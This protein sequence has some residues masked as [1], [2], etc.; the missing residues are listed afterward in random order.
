MIKTEHCAKTEEGFGKAIA[1]SVWESYCPSRLQASTEDFPC[2]GHHWRNHHGLQES[3]CLGDL[4][5]YF[6]T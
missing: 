1:D 4:H 3:G 5:K 6:K 2:R